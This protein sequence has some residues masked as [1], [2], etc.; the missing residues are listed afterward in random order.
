[1]IL[2]PT[3]FSLVP[4]GLYQIWQGYIGK[5]YAFISSFLFMAQ[6]TFYTE[7][8]G[9]SKQMIAELFFV[10]LLLVMLNKR[11]KPYSKAACFMIFSFALVT[12]HYALA[13]IFLFFISVTMISLIILKHPSRNITPSMVVLFFVIMFAW[14]IYTSRS[15][16]LNSFT[17]FGD[18][19]YKQLGEFFDPASRGQTVLR[20]LGIEAPPSIWNTIS[21]MFAYLTQALIVAGFLGLITGRVKFH[22]DIEYFLLSSLAMAFLI[23]LI[24]VP[25]LANTLNMTRFYHIL[26]F[27]LAPLCALG[28]DTTT[29]LVSKQTEAKAS[30]LL[31]VL[32]VP[33][34]LF[35][36]GFVYEVT[37]SDSWSVPLSKNRMDPLRLYGHFGYTDGYNVFGARWLSDHIEVG[38]TRIYACFYSRSDLRAYGMVYMGYIEI[39]SNTTEIA[40]NGVVYMRSL[41]VIEG[42]VVGVRHTWNT[43]EL[44]FLQ[45]LSGIYSNG[46]SAINMNVDS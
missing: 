42:T 45:D 24:A 37:Q 11:M 31:L 7:M 23:A 1:K 29:S 40:A 33:Y 22:L 35:Q 16:T 18:Y 21:R 14:Y 10:L 30:I 38:R 6:S 44:T 46:R 12:S 4:L 13:E 41:N 43:S 9:L 20:G 3:I 19:V 2:F 5:K 15:A 34:F 28:A 8:L 36:T 32:L 17:E 27:F 39:L 25:G 26:L